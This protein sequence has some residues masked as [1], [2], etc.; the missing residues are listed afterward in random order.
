MT[1]FLGS[2]FSVGFGLPTTKQL[3]ERLLRVPGK[4]PDVL[5][6]EHFISTQLRRFWEDV[7]GWAPGHPVPSLE[8]HFTQIDLAANSGHHLGPAYPPKLLR[9]LRRFTIHRVFKILDRAPKPAGPIDA[10]LRRLNEMFRLSIVTTNWDLMVERSFERSNIEFN[11]GVG[12]VDQYGDP[13]KR[14]GPPLLKLHGSGNWAYCDCCRNWIMFGPGM[15]KVAVHLHLLLE[16]D[17]FLLFPQGEI[18]AEDLDLGLDLRECSRCGGRLSTRIATFSYR[19]DLSVRA[20]QAIWDEAHTALHTARRWL[21]IGYSLPEADIEIRSLL[22][23]AQLAQKREP[24]IDIVLKGDRAAGKR[25]ARF[26][27]ANVNVFLDGLDAWIAQHL[28]DFCA[29]QEARDSGASQ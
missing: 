7:F 16:R 10:F 5:R 18:I 15:G 1:L 23:T 19:K 4:A 27:G 29:L 12:Q 13:V 22:K 11:L 20:F 3:Q 6:R 26:L 28:D 14:R 21:F 2:G 8:D 9:A 24:T 17:D 25:Y